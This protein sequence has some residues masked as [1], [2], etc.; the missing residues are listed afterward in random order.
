MTVIIGIVCIVLFSVMFMQFKTIEETDITSI[1]NMRETELRAAISEWKTKYEETAKKLETN[2]KSIKEYQEKI[3]K[4]EKATNLIDKDLKES[5]ML[6]GK[7]NVYGEGVVITITD[8]SE[9]KVSYSDLLD[10][11]NELKY[12]GAEAISIN[13]VR[14]I[15]M[16]EISQP[17]SIL[18][19]DDVR[20]SSPYVIKAIGNQTYLSSTLSLKDTGFI[21][22]YTAVGMNVKL[23]TS[24]NVQ[25]LKYNGEMDTNYM[26]EGEAE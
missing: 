16:T 5:E 15:N 20:I 13:D 7:T 2:Q 23:E 11:V 8:N 25:I 17:N 19:R 21:D 26:M 9:Y 22:K 10:L 6:L 18:M 1:E 14:I 3:E 4:N 12:A 24:K